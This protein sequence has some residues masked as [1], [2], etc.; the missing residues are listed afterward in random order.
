MFLKHIN[1][2][3]LLDFIKSTES[4]VDESL[5][6]YAT[7]LIFHITKHK[8]KSTNVSSNQSKKITKQS[9]NINVDSHSS[10][11]QND[12]RSLPTL[13]KKTKKSLVA[14]KA[15]ETDM[16]KKRSEEI[17]DWLLEEPIVKKLFFLVKN[18]SKHLV[19]TALYIFN[20]IITS[21]YVYF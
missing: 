18:R 20:N 15:K 14:Q 2:K 11:S 13:P 3:L 21:V 8:F 7:N 4:G 10:I 5:R 1:R 17:K 19:S 6:I 9:T 16:L 12:D